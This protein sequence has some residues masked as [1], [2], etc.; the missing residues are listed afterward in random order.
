MMFV[1]VQE[2]TSQGL[3]GEGEA[4]I[5]LYEKGGGCEEDRG[6]ER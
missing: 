3:E 5:F 4:L 2:S 1:V 6:G